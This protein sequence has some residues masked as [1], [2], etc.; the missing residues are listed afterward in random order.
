MLGATSRREQLHAGGS[1][2][3]HGGAAGFVAG[4]EHHEHL[5]RDLR[6]RLR[7]A[8]RRHEFARISRQVGGDH[9]GVFIAA[10][11]AHVAAQFVAFEQQTFDPSYTTCVVF[12][13]S[14]TALARARGCSL[15]VVHS[16]VNSV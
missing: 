12:G 4:R 13:A 1:V 14:K 3:E 8:E 10:M 11:V 16:T 6:A 15:R 5:Q 9:D 7:E 2:H